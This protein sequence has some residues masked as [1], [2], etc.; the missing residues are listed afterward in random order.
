MSREHECFSVRERMLRK[1]FRTEFD[2]NVLHLVM[3][4]CRRQWYILRHIIG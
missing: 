2:S 3:S 4:F 1:I